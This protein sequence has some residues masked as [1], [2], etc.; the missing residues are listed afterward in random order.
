MGWIGL[1]WVGLDWMDKLF[2]LFVPFVASF[3]FHCLFYFSF[4]TIESKSQGHGDA[5]FLLGVMHENGDGV[6]QSETAAAEWCKGV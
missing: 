6:M 2:R 5:M 4:S 3:F 1:G